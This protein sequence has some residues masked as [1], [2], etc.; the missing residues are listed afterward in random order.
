[1][2]GYT[3][4]R[5]LVFF[6]NFIFFL[7]GAGLIG[8]GAYLKLEDD[9]YL[10]LCDK[11]S[12]ATGANLLLAVGAVVLIIA[13]FGCYGAWKQNS[14]F[15]GIFFVLLLIVFVCE[16]VAGVIGGVERSKVEDE[17]RQCLNGTFVENIKGS[18]KFQGHWNKFEEKYKCCGIEDSGDYT[19]KNATAPCVNAS[20]NST[21]LGLIMSM[22]LICQIKKGGETI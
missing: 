17:L 14:C 2:C 19:D 4:I 3:C 20:Y 1:M 13:F 18:P 11:Y 16:I 22:Y 8:T 15:L 12:W 9:D 21:I 7:A 5:Y 10:D 6:F